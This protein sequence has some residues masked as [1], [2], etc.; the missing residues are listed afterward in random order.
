MDV[1]AVK[2]IFTTLP[3]DVVASVLFATIMTVATLRLGASFAIALS[4]SL[5]VSNFLF[6]ALP[7]TYMI[8][9]MLSGVTPIIAAG[10]FGALVVLL[11][12]VLYRATSTVSDGSSTP[13]FSI[14]TG[15]A[16]TVV[17]LVM[18]HITP[19]NVLWH[20]NPMIQDIFGDA[21]RLFWLLLAF[22]AFAF[23]KS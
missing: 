20:F 13:L 12:F 3:V 4:L 23:V 6:A 15:L 10:I 11:T 1:E 7:G 14:A 17:V 18:W 2:G 9:G 21:Y 16:V 19:L 22:I 8:G 5:I